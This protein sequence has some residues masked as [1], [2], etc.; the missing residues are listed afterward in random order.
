MMRTTV[1]A[2]VMAVVGISTKMK[3][4]AISK[5]TLLVSVLYCLN[6]VGV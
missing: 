5:I 4:M 6:A 1:T 2:V 3:A